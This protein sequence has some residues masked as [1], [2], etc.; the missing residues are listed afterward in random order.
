MST[1]GVE[2]LHSRP[3][4]RSYAV[5]PQYQDF[6]SIPLTLPGRRMM[7]ALKPPYK[8][9]IPPVYQIDLDLPPKERYKVIARDYKEA[10]QRLTHLFDDILS[11]LPYSGFIG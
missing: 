5:D 1:S 2:N 6:S 3:I 7:S 9:E 11:V 4:S 8:G 10:M